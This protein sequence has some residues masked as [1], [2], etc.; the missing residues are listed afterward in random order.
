MIPLLRGF[1]VNST[2]SA[3]GTEEHSRLVKLITACKSRHEEQ[4]VVDA[5]LPR[6][7]TALSSP[8]LSL[9]A[10]SDW[11]LC[12]VQLQQ[13]GCSTNFACAQA[14]PLVSSPKRKLKQL[15]YTLARVL[16]EDEGELVLLLTNTLFKVGTCRH[17]PRLSFS[18]VKLIEDARPCVC[19]S[20]NHRT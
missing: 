9:A 13:L 17:R 6:I 20:G 18:G 2:A 16:S 3:A 10:R 19:P 1:Y 7:K 4:S 15:G 8:S 5:E 12:L 11:L 14:L